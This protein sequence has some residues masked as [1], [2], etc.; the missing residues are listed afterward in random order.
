MKKLLTALL[1][2]LIFALAACGG[3]DNG[4]QDETDQAGNDSRTVVTVDRDI[5]EDDTNEEAPAP[6]DTPD[7]PP[8]PTGFTFEANG[9]VIYMDQNMTDVLALLGHTDDVFEAPSCAF[10]GIDRIFRFPGVQIHTYPDGDED[11]VHTI[12]IR[13][14]SVTT[15]NGIFIGSSLGDV[16]AAYGSDYE[17]EFG[18]FRYTLGRTT[19]SFFVEDDIVTGILYELIME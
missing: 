15:L 12:N 18:M 17:Q 9:A 19:L 8:A 4:P 5:P 16:I 7:T 2:G 13:D 3:A 10:D 6:P 11:F 1:L 14:D